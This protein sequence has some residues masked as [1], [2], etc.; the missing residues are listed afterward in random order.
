MESDEGLDTGTPNAPASP[1]LQR[2]YSSDSDE[3]TDSSKRRKLGCDTDPR[4]ESEL[5][6]VPGYTDSGKASEWRLELCS[7][8][9]E[10]LQLHRL[11]NASGIR[12][13]SGSSTF[14]Q[15]GAAPTNENA[16]DSYRL[17]TLATAERTTLTCSD[18]PD[19]WC[20]ATISAQHVAITIGHQIHILSVDCRKQ[21][22]VVCHDSDIL[23]TSLN[24][25]SS[26]VAF[27][28]ATGTLFIVHI[29]TRR[30]M[31]SQVIKPPSSFP[32]ITAGSAMPGGSAIVALQFAVS[33]STDANTREELVV[34]TSEGTLVRFSSL[35]L[36]LLS[37]AILDSD[38]AMAAKIKGEIKIEFASLSFSDRP[39]HS[40]GIGGVSL[41]HSNGSSHVVVVG[42][43]DA[44]M[45]CWCRKECSELDGEDGDGQRVLAATQL[46]DIVSLECSGSGYV[47]VAL[48]LDQRYLVALSKSGSL[49]VYERL[50]L[51]LVFRYID[52]LIDDF[53]LLAPGSTKAEAL[54]PSSI[55]LAAISKPVPLGLEHDDSED[56]DEDLCRRLLVISLPS[57]EVVY[58]MDASIWSWLAHDIRSSQDVADTILF[59]EGTHVDGMQTFYLRNLYETVPME[60]L[61]HFLRAGRFTE[62]EAFAEENGIPLAVVYRKRLED[63]LSDSSHPSLSELSSEDE[64]AAFVEQTLE[65]LSHMDD[66]AF[67]IDVC[68]RLPIPSFQSTQRLLLHGRTLAEKDTPSMAKVMDSIQRLGTWCIIGNGGLKQC[69]TMRFDGLAWQSFRV[70][71]LA[72]C[73]RSFISR[74]DIER[75]GAI[76]RRH[77]SDKRL[78]SDIASAIQGFPADVDT[79][80]LAAWLEREVLPLF[81]TRQQWSDIAIWIEQRARALESSQASLQGALRLLELLEPGHSRSANWSENQRDQTSGLTALSGRASALPRNLL[82]SLPL[83]VTPQRFIEGSLQSAAWAA[84]L[85]Q[86]SGIPVFSVAPGAERGSSS[87]PSTQSCHFLRKQL[88]DL[89]YLRD[90]HHM[91][92]TLDRYE[93]MSYSMI[94]MELLDRVAA[95]EL[96]GNAYFDHFVPYAQRHQLECSQIIHKYCIDMMDSVDRDDPH[97]Y[98]SGQ[99]DT[100]DTP[101]VVSGILGSTGRHT[102]EPRVICILDSLYSSCVGRG[103]RTASADDRAGLDTAAALPLTTARLTSLKTYFE[104]V[105]EVM[106]RSTIPWSSGIDAT[107]EKCFLLFGVY[108]DLEE[109]LKKC[110]LD[111][112]DQYRLMCLKRMLLSYGLHDFHISNTKMACPLLQ[113]LVRKTD[114]S[115]IMSDALQLVD[116]YH[117]LSRTLAYVLRMQALCEAGE[118]AAVAN[119]VRFIDTTE[120]GAATSYFGTQNDHG[121][122]A[123]L[124]F[125][126]RSEVPGAVGPRAGRPIQR[127]VPMEVARRC[128]CWIREMLDNMTFVGESSRAQFKQ[129][130][131]AAMAMLRALEELAQQYSRRQLP[132]GNAAPN[133]E[134]EHGIVEPELQRLTRFVSKESR[135]LGVVWQLIVDGDVM[136]SPGELEH[137]HARE[138]ILADLINR[139]WLGP[140]VGSPTKAAA[141]VGTGKGQAKQLGMRARPSDVATVAPSNELTSLPSIPASIKALAVMLRFSSAQLWHQIV[142]CCLSLGLHFV[143]LDMCQHIVMAIKPTT[144]LTE[145]SG[146]I[147]WMHEPLDEWPVALSALAACE[148][149]ICVYLAGQSSGGQ[150]GGNNQPNL[151]GKRQGLLV[152]RLVHVCQAASL[153]CADLPQLTGFLDAYSCWDLAQSIFDKTTDGD[154]AILTRSRSTDLPLAHVAVHG[155]GSGAAA[156]L[157]LLPH[158]ASR[159]LTGAIEDAMAS[160]DISDDHESVLA[161]WLGPLFASSYVERGLVLDTGK[162]MRLVYRLAS[163]L[164][165]LPSISASGGYKLASSNMSGAG[166]KGKHEARCQSEKLGDDTKLSLLSAEDMRLV[167]IKRCGDLVAH[168]ASNLHWVLAVQTLELTISQLARSSFVMDSGAQSES[169]AESLDLLQQRL[170]SGGISEDELD[171]LFGVGDGVGGGGSGGGNTTI[172]SVKGLVSKILTQSL[173]QRRGADVVFIFS[174]ML[175]SDVALAF[176][177]L[178]TA[179]SLSGMLPSRVISLANIGVACSLLWKQHTMLDRCRSVVTAARWSGQLQLL[180]LKFKVEQLNNPKPELLEPLVRPMLIK[181]AMDIT[182]VLEFAD[183]F[184][185]DETNVIVE[186]ISL[187]CSDPA[188][189]GYQARIIGIVDEIANTK[190]LER[191]FTDS[192]VNDISAYDYERLQFVVQ[193][194]QDLRPQDDTM[195]GKYLAVLDILCSYDRKG[196]PTYDELMQE[197]SRTRIARNSIKQRSDNDD[198]DT[199]RHEL[200]GVVGGREMAEPTYQELAAEFSLAS[201]RLPF[202]YL[203]NTSPWA[204]ILPELST[205]TVEALLPLAEPLGLSKDDFYI[206]LIDNMIQ[207]WKSDEEQGAQALKAYEQAISKT[208]THFNAVEPLIQC[209]RDPEARISTIKHAADEL[210]C[211]PNRIAALNFG[212]KELVKWGRRIKRM[213]RNERE[214]AE[215]KA[216]T[217][218]GLFK[219]SLA[220]ANTEVTLRRNRLERYLPLFTDAQDVDAAVCALAAVFEGECEGA[221][222]EAGQEEAGTLH[223]VLRNLAAIN[224]IGMDRLIRELLNR[225]LKAPVVFASESSELQLPSIRYHATLRLYSSQEAILHRR[226]TYLL[227]IQAMPD[228]IAALLDFAYQSPGIALLCRMRA[229]GILLSIASSE[230][231]ALALPP[232][233]VHQYLQALLYVADFEHVGIRQSTNDFLK[234][235]KA[236]LARSI[237]VDYHEDAKVTLLVCNMC[238]DFKVGDNDLITRMLSQLLAAGMHRYVIGVLDIIGGMDCQPAIGELPRFWNLAVQGSLVQ[239]ARTAEAGWIG[240]GLTVLDLCAR[241]IHFPLVDLDGVVRVLLQEARRNSANSAPVL[242][243][244]AALDILL[245]SGAAEGL[246]RD[247]IETM[248][249]PHIHSLVLGL[250]ELACAASAATG[251]RSGVSWELSHGLTLLF[252]VVDS[253]GQHEQA[254]LRPPMG[255]AIHA[256]VCNRIHHDKLLAAVNACLERGKRQLAGQLVSRYYQTRTVDVLLADALQAGVALGDGG[257][258]EGSLLSESPTA[259]Q[260]ATAAMRRVVGE[261]TEQQKLELYI[262]S[263]K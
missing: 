13:T 217:I 197:W 4:A 44:C 211:G 196:K 215:P 74:G 12:Q 258:D 23:A 157:H 185:L 121:Y 202:H 50:T 20:D 181:T 45:S 236:A 39:I 15:R 223:G 235:D 80:S 111:I 101:M 188:V 137:Q 30:P 3:G 107:I 169:T 250:Q 162:T 244:F 87:D 79:K 225:Y 89:E 192:I 193:R 92:L 248:Q 141:V 18:S 24:C 5:R 249:P 153:K 51:T 161:S 22:A 172:R 240:D 104:I 91:P 176:D 213:P 7:G 263:H 69:P 227:R 136:V 32:N 52:T 62:A 187:C 201:K 110:R 228:A 151:S 47:K 166:S 164:R 77:Q 182:T 222:G 131:N 198:D 41:T 132:F 138:K 95:P 179:M 26:F 218:Y 98:A 65:M 237:W 229:L 11:S 134:T 199:H 190:L 105:L 78:C 177:Q 55:L 171:A 49:D 216:N 140:L 255:T 214:H 54:S 117:H 158:G 97:Q 155:F 21:E 85:S 260:E 90:V 115:T 118:A 42:S 124:S 246:L 120:H 163:A 203:V 170:A 48:S 100:E 53:S 102:W 31:F 116:A 160:T 247:F 252:D 221:L 28:D 259:T 241:S 56:D 61:S 186:Y 6:N 123:G 67:A 230:D 245:P 113:W 25:D 173:Q 29:K 150:V 17:E 34:V 239:L 165:R 262:C 194:L 27:G 242:M 200:K 219:K 99:D 251:A 233:N 128:I 209:C 16:F 68:M 206:N 8:S 238:L 82:A 33:Q 195:I 159:G 64:V 205:E 129:L 58:S 243:A 9:D 112:S 37:Q 2:R 220:D 1:S 167:V 210:P 66:T 139:R 119:L 63:I 86:F 125:L 149:E 46:A 231:I 130:V 257:S 114:S 208:P 76:W 108:G 146:G 144:S 40:G 36:C 72:T 156:S 14:T 184:R 19:R 189:D 183:A 81:S 93:Q 35:Q 142:V 168:L 106:R 143:A 145:T 84:G 234:C 133:L 154:F 71:D 232:A 135:A 174:A 175:A 57:M 59:I 226:I 10:T 60:R 191:I 147:D 178:S 75:A 70:S 88:L 94:A 253:K 103:S 204:T 212:L 148:R 38:M 83:T 254:L 109:D 122:L 207:Q 127:Y 152:R 126:I 43:G 96:L 224:E 261:L 180:Q 256:F 73:M